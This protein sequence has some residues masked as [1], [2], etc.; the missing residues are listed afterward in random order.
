VVLAVIAAIAIAGC[1]AAPAVRPTWPDAPVQ[2]RDDGDRDAAIDRLWILPPGPERDRERA[3]VA[4]AI[5]RRMAEAIDDE[6]PF[7]AAALLEQLSSLWG[8]DPAAIGPGLAPHVALLRR[9]RALLART[10]ALEPAVRALVVLFEVEPTR[11]VAHMTELAEIIGFAEQLAVAEHGPDGRRA[12]PIALFQPTAV[13]LPIRWVVDLY[14]GMLVERQLAV[15]AVLATKGASLGLVRAQGDLLSTSRRIAI[16]LARA[17]RAG[18]IHAALAR[19]EPGIGATTEGRDRELRIAAELVAEQPV[20]DSF[21][22]LAGRLRTDDRAPSPAAALAVELA[23]LARHPEEPRLLAAAAGDAR[24]LG[25]IDQAIA[26][27]ERALAGAPEVDAALAL[28]LGR[29]YAERIARLASAGRPRAAD[30]AWREATRYAAATARARPHAVWQE[31]LATAEA[32]LGR[33]LA[34]QGL[35]DEGRRALTASALRAASVEAYE[36]LAVIDTQVDRFAAA[37]RWVRAG[38]ALLGDETAGDRY[39]RARLERRAADALRRAGKLREAGDRYLDALRAWASLGEARKL[40]PAISAERLLDSARILWR[41]GDPGRA[42][43][44]ALDAIELDPGSS[45]IV[46]GAVAF[47]IEAGRY[48]DALDAC[49]RAL[50]EPRV[51]ELHKIYASLWIVGEARR[52]GE[53]RD[54]LAYEYLASR[55]GDLWH[56]LLARAATG[57]LDYAALRAAAVTGPRQGELAF[58]G[59]VL[60]LA[61]E[62]AAPAGQRRLLQQVLAA[63]AVLDAE[64]DLAR[65]YLAPAAPAPAAPAAPAP[66]APAAPLASSR[67]HVVAPPR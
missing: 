1:G 49:H 14:V 20:A 54:R 42:V 16:V 37:Q 35:V 7:A 21:L 10:G 64:Y 56:E 47:L 32:A 26:L 46:G 19:L 50:A 44:Y 31:A 5:A 38:L 63:R 48:R 15:A 13:A 67:P 39:R 58:Y 52:A 66:A 22:A 11:R 2:L 25:R 3:A 30:D 62:A 40:P 12:L 36:T 53:P 6:Q 34:G 57:R 43:D 45:E 4:A 29:L 8:D 24:T 27:H 55:R 17:G 61:P 65:A 28:R 23:G 18:E 59:A 60:G 33:G 9:A 51:P 41:L